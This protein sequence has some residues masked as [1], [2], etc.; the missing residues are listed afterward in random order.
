M[1]WGLEEIIGVGDALA[2]QNGLPNLP[3]TAR[4]MRCPAPPPRNVDE[5]A[6]IRVRQSRPA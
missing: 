1:R 3:W 4:I 6:Q 2:S 5:G